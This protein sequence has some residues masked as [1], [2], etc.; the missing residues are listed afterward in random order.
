[1]SSAHPAPAPAAEVG[2]S[3]AADRAPDVRLER[4]PLPAGRLRILHVE[5][6]EDDHALTV[7]QLSRAG[8]RADF[9]RVDDLRAFEVAL[10]E[11]WDAILSDYNL[12]GFTGLDVLARFRE[13]GLVLPFI[14]VS[15]E[16]GED[17]AV[18]AMRSGASDYLL[19]QNLA[20]LAPALERAIEASE[21]R[22]ARL[23]A[24]QELAASRQRLSE[25]AQHLQT[26]I[27]S[28]RSAISREIHDD[29][30]GSLTALRFDLAWMARRVQDGEVL[31]RLASAT[32]TVTHAIEASQ[33]I[34]HNLRPAILEQGLVAALQWMTRSF[35]QRHGIATV[36]R[37]SHESLPGLP[38]GVPLVA[39][40]TVQEALT[41]VSKHAKASRVTV[42]LSLAHG[43]LSL[44]IVDN[45]RGLDEGALAKARSFG[46]RGLHERAGTVGG[47]I[48]LSSGSGGTMLMLSVPLDQ[49]LCASPEEGG[50]VGTGSVDTEAW[51]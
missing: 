33:R 50:P 21:S 36:F 12:P 23:K 44:E 27:E 42:D 51:G 34:M 35:E 49:A 31:Q 41:N 26:S 25:L 8:L 48:D 47:W 40:R 30:G 20:R 29:V 24:D 43:V 1:L 16:I 22:R 10:A 32:E 3:S 18:E 19:K 4:L 17:M 45:G 5:D 9:R 37:S 15:G 11:P 2:S 46:I 7:L 28:E 38:P 14:L 13:T 39:Y 6:S